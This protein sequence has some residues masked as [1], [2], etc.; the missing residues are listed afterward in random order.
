MHNE[1]RIPSAGVCIDPSF[2]FQVPQFILEHYISSGIG[3]EVNIICT[4]PRRLAAVG[5]ASRVAEEMGEPV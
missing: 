1:Y 4:Q 5:V 3:G 2:S